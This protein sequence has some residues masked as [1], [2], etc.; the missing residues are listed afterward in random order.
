MVTQINQYSDNILQIE[1]I[2]F[3]L[4]MD[5]SIIQNRLIPSEVHSHKYYEMFFIEKGDMCISFEDTHLNV[6]EN[7][8]VIIPPHMLHHT[9]SHCEEIRLCCIEFLAIP[10]EKQCKSNTFISLLSIE[11]PLSLQINSPLRDAFSRFAMYIRGNAKSKKNLLGAC[12]H[13][14][15]YLL[16]DIYTECAEVSIRESDLNGEYRG[17][18]IENYINQNLNHHISLSE[19][20][21]LLYLSEQQ[22]NYIIKKTYGQSFHKRVLSLRMQNATKLLCETDMM[23][24]NIAISVGYASVHGFYSAFEKLYGVT[25]EQYRQ[26]HTK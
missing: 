23:I 21:G 17:Y 25:P 26:Q 19:L 2:I 11:K 22:V 3:T 20:A 12:F 5:E 10:T 7:S 8:I 9:S 6:S 14:M 16:K 18:V 4:I 24:K 15:I 13:E 1:N